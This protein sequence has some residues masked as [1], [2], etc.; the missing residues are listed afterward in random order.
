MRIW[1]TLLV[2]FALP[3]VITATSHLKNELADEAHNVRKHYRADDSYRLQQLMCGNVSLANDAV[4]E[5]NSSIVHQLHWS[6]FCILENHYSLVLKGDNPNTQAVV[7]CE[8]T[9]AGNRCG[10]GFYN[11]TSLTIEYV[12]FKNF[13]CHLSTL[14]PRLFKLISSKNGPQIPQVSAATMLIIQS[15]VVFKSLKITSYQGFAV[16]GANLIQGSTFTT[17]TVSDSLSSFYNGSGILIYFSDNGKMAAELTILNSKFENNSITPISCKPNDRIDFNFIRFA[18]G[19]TIIYGQQNYSAN[20]MISESHF[21]LNSGVFVGAVSIMHVNSQLSSATFITGTS[22]QENAACC[23]CNGTALSLYFFQNT[24]NDKSFTTSP[25]N[26]IDTNFQRHN[27]DYHNPNSTSGVI[28][29]GVNSRR[30][31]EIVFTFARVNFTENAILSTG[32]CMN[33]NSHQFEHNVNILLID[34]KAES[35]FLHQQINT[36]DGQGFGSLFAFIGIKHILVSG[37]KQRGSLF[38]NNSATVLATT[39]SSIFLEGNIVF[40]NNRATTG[41]AIKM[42]GFSYLYLK[43][44]SNIL[45]RNNSAYTLGGA[46]YIYNGMMISPIKCVFQIQENSRYAISVT[47]MNNNAVYAG[48]SIFA[49]PIYDCYMNSNHMSS[50]KASNYYKEVFKF[51]DNTVLRSLSTVPK[52]LTLESQ[53]NMI[54][55]YPGKQFSVCIAA[56]DANGRFVYSVIGVSIELREAQQGNQI[57]INKGSEHILKEYSMCT[58]IHITLGTHK[59]LNVNGSLV[60]SAPNHVHTISLQIHLQ[61]CLL[62]FRLNQFSN[63]CECELAWHRLRQSENIQCNISDGTIKQLTPYFNVWAGTVLLPDGKEV[64]GVSNNCPFG[65]CFYIHTAQFFIAINSTTIG[66]LDNNNIRKPSICG[67][68]R[69]GVLCGA[70]EKGYSTLI[71]GRNCQKCSNEWLWLIIVYAVVGPLLIYLLYALRLTLTTGTLNGIIFYA[72]AVANLGPNELLQFSFRFSGI[73][74][75]LSYILRIFVQPFQLQ[76]PL[77]M[78]FFNG[79]TELWRRGLVIIFPLYILTIVAVLIILSRFSIRVSNR[80]AHSSVQVL[81]TVIHLSFSSILVLLVDTF[82]PGYIHTSDS[83]IVV[84]YWDGNV[85]YGSRH[86]VVLMVIS[87][88]VGLSF[89]LPYILLLLFSKPVRRYR[90]IYMY[91]QNILDC[92][93]APYKENK[94]YWFVLRLFFFTASYIVYTF[95]PNISTSVCIICIFLGLVTIAQAYNKP[96]KSKF[97]DCLDLSIMINLFVLASTAAVCLVFR[98]YNI[99]AAITVCFILVV[100]L[101]FFAVIVGHVLWVT[102][103]YKT[104]NRRFQQLQSCFS[105]VNLSYNDLFSSHQALERYDDSFYG[106]CSQ[107]REPLLDS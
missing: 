73:L 29:I 83:V 7:Q 92:I 78:C 99:V 62:G 52:E 11:L 87:T 102:G 4:V 59:N 55:T 96:F 23:C 64:F 33:V 15:E 106:S 104:F 32:S 3:Q 58:L 31:M 49:F 85:P 44:S 27:G 68:H 66:L 69:I 48:S 72:Q 94:Q 98:K 81:V 24:R 65:H 34:V 79:M 91:T 1:F 47:F 21:T 54:T 101:T 67:D 76:L 80:I 100:M 17:L 5:L 97:I 70:C 16:I 63:I 88:F 13:G 61:K 12:S 42:E 28:W 60:F 9:I 38:H 18:A 2:V 22:F 43:K 36:T 26:I 105:T 10:F 84:W 35:N 86:H 93:H 90:R 8:A 19:L 25:L 39:S 107:F 51:H 41:A 46:I 71:S 50:S 57:F 6:N 75:V 40:S 53:N 45:F 14:D 77:P 20:V 89:L 82:T 103:K 37:S 74:E 30:Y 95:V 56:K